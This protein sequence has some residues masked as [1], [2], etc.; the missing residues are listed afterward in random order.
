MSKRLYLLLA[1]IMLVPKAIF[2]Q[3]VTLGFGIDKPP[4]ITGEEEG[5][6]VDLAKE[7]FKRLGYSTIKILHMS[8]KRIVSSLKNGV[9]TA[10]PIAKG[11]PGVDFCYTSTSF[12]DFHNFVIT[13]ESSDLKPKSVQDLA[14][15]IYDIAAFQNAVVTIG[16]EYAEVVRKNKN[17][18]E[19]GS[20]KSQVKMFLTGRKN[21][22]V[23][24]RYI[25]Q[26]WA[27][28]L[29]PQERPQVLYHPLFDKVNSLYF[30]FRAED[31]ELCEKFSRALKG[32]KDDGT[33]K[34]IL[35]KRI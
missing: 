2:A 28:V 27:K 6:E 32:M 15:P 34:K 12:I 29:Q 19:F 35:G 5:V 16:P 31:K 25:Y 24:D 22:L 23:I 3:D 33:Y 11:N 7:A 4:F 9:I 18:H 30:G 17:Y 1:I 13:R 14:N 10:G 8:N 26:Y 21:S 20:Q